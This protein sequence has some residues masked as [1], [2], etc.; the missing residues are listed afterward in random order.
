MLF[1]WLATAL[2][3]GEREEIAEPVRPIEAVR[4]GDPTAL[5][6]TQFPGTA[7]ALQFADLSFRVEGTVEAVPARLG[8]RVEEGEVVAQLVQRDFIVRVRAAEASVAQARATM[9][10]AQEEVT[11]QPPAKA[12]CGLGDVRRKM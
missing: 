11:V 12:L 5:R 4:V 7:E 3:C 10:E 1:V 6:G 8:N 9:A 2:S